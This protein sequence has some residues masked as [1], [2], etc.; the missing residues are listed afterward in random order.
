MKRI[1]VT[2]LL[3]MATVASFAQ[4]SIQV[5]NGISGT[6][7]PIYG[8][9]VGNET[10]SLRGGSSLSQPAGS[11]TYTGGLLSGDRY[12]ME[13]WAGPASATEYSALTL[14]TTIGFRTG[15]GALPNGITATLPSG[16]IPGV[17]AGSQ[18]KLGVRVWDTQSGASW[19][20]ATVRGEGL[21]F[22]SAPLGGNPPGG[23]TPITPPAWVGESFSLYVVPEPSSMALAGL[24][25]ASL[26]IFRRRK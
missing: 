9:Q 14:I 12:Q 23:G 24:G 26:L 22:L 19:L 2:T 8:P 4:G 15:T 25:A 20:T 21:L 5:G 17:D 16:L 3:A 11:V 10:V 7:F 13:F 18:A 6:R 1:L